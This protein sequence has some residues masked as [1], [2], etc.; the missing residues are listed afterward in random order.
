MWRRVINPKNYSQE[1]ALQL[2]IKVTCRPPSAAMNTATAG[3]MEVERA[4]LSPRK[5]GRNLILQRIL[6][7]ILNSSPTSFPHLK[8]DRPFI[9]LVCSL[10]PPA[11]EEVGTEMHVV[12]GPG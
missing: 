11:L 5:K 7:G 8:S 2:D 4:Q 12:L 9:P 10:E 1:H 6:A 3:L